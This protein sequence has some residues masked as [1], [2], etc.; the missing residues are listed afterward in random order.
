MRKMPLP[1]AILLGAATLVCSVAAHDALVPV[2]REL[3]T[4]ALIGAIGAYRAHVSPRLAG[5]VRCR[6]EPTCS[7]YGLESVRKHGALRGGWKAARRIARCTSAT[8]MGT[9]DHP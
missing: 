3:S 9:V 4:R 2:E 5:R 7:A 8:P 6:F 1:A